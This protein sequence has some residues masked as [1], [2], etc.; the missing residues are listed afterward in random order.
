LNCLSGLF[1]LQKKD[2]DND[3]GEERDDN[4]AENILNSAYGDDKFVGK[5]SV[6]RSG[7]R[8]RRCAVCR[9]KIGLTGM[10][11]ICR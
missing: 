8:K 4:E 10:R 9:K 3:V 1:A 7:R 2:Y 5:C 6:V 11:N